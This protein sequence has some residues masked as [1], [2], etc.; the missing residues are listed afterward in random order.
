MD[1]GVIDRGLLGALAP[2]GARVRSAEPLA[3]HTSFRIGGPADVFVLPDTVAELALVVR[4]A[5]S[6]RVPLT[7]LGGGSNVLVG[8]GG[9]RGVV[10]KLAGEFRRAQWRTD[11]RPGRCRGPARSARACGGRPRSRGS[12]VRGGHSRDRRRRDV[13]ERRRVR[14]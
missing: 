4:A 12:R 1:E 8:D 11:A 2:L 13:H 14:R 10:V 9:I 7:V 3:R 5:A 6:H